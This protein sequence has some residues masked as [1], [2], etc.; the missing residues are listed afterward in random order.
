MAAGHCYSYV[1]A[2]NKYIYRSLAWPHDQPWPMGTDY[3]SIGLSPY[4]VTSQPSAG[5]YSKVC[6]C[7]MLYYVE[8]KDVARTV[9]Y[10]ND[11]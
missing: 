1:R 7:S 11:S 9:L 5:S 8:R 6:L 4:W 2:V 10:D 3:Y